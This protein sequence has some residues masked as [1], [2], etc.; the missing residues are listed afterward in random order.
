[1]IL[2]ADDVL[3]AAV[4][5][6]VL[7]VDD[8][9]A[10][11]CLR[12]DQPVVRVELLEDGDVGGLRRH[13][14]G[15]FRAAAD[16]QLVRAGDLLDRVE[17]FQALAGQREMR[18]RAAGRGDH[19]AP[20]DKADDD[21]VDVEAFV[22]VALPPP[23]VRQVAVALDRGI[24]I[25]IGAVRADG[26]GHPA[27]RT[28]IEAE[29]QVALPG[30]V[31][32]VNPH[33]PP[34][35]GVEQF[36]DPLP[37]VRRGVGRGR[38]EPR[39]LVQAA[40]RVARRDGRV[41]GRQ[42]M[43]AERSPVISPDPDPRAVEHRVARGPRIAFRVEEVVHVERRLVRVDAPAEAERV[44]DQAAVGPAGQIVVVADRR[45][46]RQLL[47]EL[48]RADA[49]LGVDAI[50]EVFV[51]VGARFPLLQSEVEA[52]SAVVLVVVGDV[53]RALVEVRVAAV[54]ESRVD[55]VPLVVPASL[56]GVPEIEVQRREGQPG[57]CVAGR[58]AGRAIGHAVVVRVEHDLRRPRGAE[59]VKPPIAAAG[60][61]HVRV[62][63]AVD[64]LRP[65][66]QAGH[67][68]G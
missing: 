7:A 60:E 53:R 64:V 28:E 39:K 52:R 23:G 26:R 61:Q 66:A 19:L 62:G 3:V 46:V 63:S 51:V 27:G 56:G 38:R 4:A 29:L 68:D 11:G 48:A 45:V 35:A 15:V 33:L 14:V 6:D 32:Q 24:E 47:V 13:V 12:G 41:V 40:S 17:R 8:V 9:A 65:E 59:C 18:C 44:R 1:M 50:A 54:V 42:Q 43:P 5:A 36:L 2:L 10:V 22:G 58:V 34:L 67:A 31:S 30:E 16:L 37:P 25:C 57:D 55:A 21:V 20:L 49:V